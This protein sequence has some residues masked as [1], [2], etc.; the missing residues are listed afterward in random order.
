MNSASACHAHVYILRKQSMN[1]K[2]FVDA[3]NT[4][5]SACH[6]VEL[7]QHMGFELLCWRPSR[8]ALLAA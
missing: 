1:A 2:I 4:A 3:T 6:A 8:V 7:S 5:A